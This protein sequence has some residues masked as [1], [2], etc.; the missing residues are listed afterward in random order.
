[1]IDSGI[2]DAF[3]ELFIYFN[4]NYIT[5]PMTIAEPERYF[6]KDLPKE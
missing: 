3:I 4:D 5:T 1:M 6:F 2:G